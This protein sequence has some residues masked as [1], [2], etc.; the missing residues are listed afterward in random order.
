MPTQLS[1]STI[2]GRAQLAAP[3]PRW[4]ACPPPSPLPPV[5]RCGSSTSSGA[6]GK[7]RPKMNYPVSSPSLM[8]KRTERSRTLRCAVPFLLAGTACRA[9]PCRTISPLRGYEQFPFFTNSS[10]F[11]ER[12]RQQAR[13]TFIF[14]FHLLT[15][16]AKHPA[17]Q[18]IRPPTACHPARLLLHRLRLP[19]RPTRVG[20]TYRKTKTKNVLSCFISFTDE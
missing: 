4:P 9:T 13:V 6:I 8:D 2:T 18:L 14:S 10:S 19:M 16:S 17:G 5:S 20:Q 3:L 1:Y 15:D 11:W 7:Q 12:W